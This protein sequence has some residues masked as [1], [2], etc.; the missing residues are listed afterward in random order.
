[1]LN[2]LLISLG[3][4]EEEIKAYASLLELGP[5]TVG[6]L[7]KKIGKPR[8]SLYGFLK[9]LQEKG[10]V[11]QSSKLGTKIFLAESPAKGACFSG[12]KLKN[13]KTKK[14]YIKI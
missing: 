13:W 9:R 4:T 7:A 2:N 8:A 10:V 6:N 5:M 12:K 11:T 1:M 14:K 3:L